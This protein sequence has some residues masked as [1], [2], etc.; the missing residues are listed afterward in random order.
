[1][2]SLLKISAF[3]FICLV[4][5][6]YSTAGPVNAQNS[7]DDISKIIENSPASH[8]LWAVQ[9]RDS[10][11]RLLLDINGDKVVRP[12]SNLKL[13]SSAAFLDILGE[14]FQF[15]TKLYTRGEIVN[16]VLR[17]DLIIRGSGDP[18]INRVTYEDPLDVFD[19]WYHIL[20]SLGITSIDGNIIGHYGYFDDVPYP[21][22]WE[23]DDL[24]YYYAPEISALSF[25]SNVVDLEVSAE[26]EIGGVPKIEWEPFNT[27]YVQFVNEQTITPRNSRF[28]E[29][30]RR[31]LGSNTIYLRSSL[32]LGYYE[33]E[34]LS[35]HNPPRYFID[36]LQRYL[37]IREIPVRGQLLTS[38]SYINWDSLDLIHNHKSPKLSEIVVQLNRESDNFYA[39][40]LIKKLS[41]KQIGENGSTENGLQILK[42]FMHSMEIDTNLVSLRDGSGMAPATLIRASDLNHFLVNVQSKPYFDTFYRSM[43]VGGRNGTLKYRF[44]RNSTP[45]LFHGKSGF[46]SGVRALSGYMES[47]SGERL[48][49]TIVT[50]NYT[51]RTLL[52][53]MTHERIVDY[54]YSTY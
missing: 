19:E 3:P 48:V 49:V 53:D 42:G 27:P 17:G 40:M 14:D 25:N 37:K 30:Y 26:G 46:V 45:A 7:S 11:G 38:R 23:W 18:T 50:N 15:E 47:A 10:D 21:R 41:A 6:V 24:S 8:A 31:V 33:T 4:L 2:K 51:V 54:L 22:G 28:D 9:V 5:L 34:P 1:M 44:G 35:I 32:P 39:E 36:T 16:G 12:A 43:S 52:V 20:D 13:I 29:S